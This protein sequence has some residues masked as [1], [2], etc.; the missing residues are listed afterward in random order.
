MSDRR[1]RTRWDRA[2][3]FALPA[4][5]VLLFSVTHYPRVRI[6]GDLPQR[7]KLVHFTAFGLL[8]LL[9]W[10][11]VQA[12]RPIGDRFVW[13][14]GAALIAYAAF[15]EYVQQFVGRFTDLA[16]LGANTAGIA[17]VL[18]ALEV[19]RRRRARRSRT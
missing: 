7:D 19:Q 15:D 4:Y 5:W 8:A 9:L 12:R 10:R 1:P 2:A 16:D 3:L 13:G 17:C 18:T 14:A 6:P 11:F